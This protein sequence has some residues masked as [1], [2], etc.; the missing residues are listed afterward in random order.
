[1]PRCKQKKDAESSFI[2]LIT[3]LVITAKA[4]VASDINIA[5]QSAFTN[6]LFNPKP[7][8]VDDNPYQHDVM[9]ARIYCRSWL[10]TINPGMS[11][12]LI[13]KWL[14]EL[15]PWGGANHG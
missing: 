14:D 4:K 8:R 13:E 12:S 1:M 3:T 7:Y 2:A 5:E 9:L 15:H 10:L 11:Q 6:A